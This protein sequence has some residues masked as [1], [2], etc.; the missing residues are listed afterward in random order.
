MSSFKI[1]FLFVLCIFSGECDVLYRQAGDEISLQCDSPS[2]GDIDW[3]FN[4]IL[5]ITFVA[6]RGTQRKGTSNEVAHI[7]SKAN[8]NGGTLKIPR[9]ETRDSGVY[10]CRQSGKQYTVR[11]GSVFAKPAIT[12][13]GTEAELHCS[14]TGEPQ[15]K[16][17]WLSP[18]GLPYSKINQVISLKP[19]TSEYDGHWTCQIKDLKMNVRLTVVDLQTNDVEVP[20]GGDIVLPC[21]LSNSAF[22]PR[23]VGGK[24]QADHLPSVSFPTLENTYDKGLHWKGQNSSKVKFT[25]GKLGTNFDIHLIKVQRSYAGEYVCTVEFE[26]GTNLTAVATLKFVA[27]PS[28]G[29]QIV[30]KVKGPWTKD[31]LGVQLWV[32]IAVGVSSVVLI[33]LIILTALVQRRNKQMKRR[34]RKLR[35]MRQP[36]TAKDY[37]QCNRSERNMELGKVMRPVPVPRQ[38]RNAYNSPKPYN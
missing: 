28:G 4:S 34:V 30:T 14:I 36:L 16:V 29:G 37:C 2:H 12:R 27:G 1:F 31:V 26:D 19:V 8:A 32:W 10:S 18:N 13:L 23:V 6:K 17:Q 3:E 25:S 33:G 5:L 15:T 7:H 35:S 38:Q 21:S 20:E 22:N 24:W 9:L 11:V